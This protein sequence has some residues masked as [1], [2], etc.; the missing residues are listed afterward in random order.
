MT[1]MRDQPCLDQTTS[2]GGSP[3][4]WLT[5]DKRQLSYTPEEV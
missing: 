5:G 2:L 4:I 1:T 3:W